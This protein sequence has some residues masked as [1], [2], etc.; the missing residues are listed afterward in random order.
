MHRARG[1]CAVIKTPCPEIDTAGSK[2]VNL[3]QL[4]REFLELCEK[5][6]E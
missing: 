2:W 5:E 1:V 3:Y 6:N 4:N